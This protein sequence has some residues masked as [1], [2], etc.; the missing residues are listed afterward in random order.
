MLN[1]PNFVLE[2]LAPDGG[3][4]WGDE[5]VHLN[6]AFTK[7][8]RVL[9]LRVSNCDRTDRVIFNKVTKPLLTLL[10]DRYGFERQPRTVGELFG[11]FDYC[12]R[13]DAIVGTEMVDS[14][15]HAEWQRLASALNSACSGLPCSAAIEHYRRGEANALRLFHREQ[16]T[17]SALG[18]AYRFAHAP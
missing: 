17:L 16:E 3:R 13:L 8:A 12:D 18:R 7:L 5:P 10:L 15:W 2:Q 14:P 1:V 11:L 6:P 4:E 9:G